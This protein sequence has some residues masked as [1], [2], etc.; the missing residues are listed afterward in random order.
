MKPGSTSTQPTHPVNRAGAAVSPGQSARGAGLLACC[1]AALLLAGC[2]RINSAPPDVSRLYQ[3][4]RAAL[5]VRVDDSVVLAAAD[6][7]KVPLRVAYPEGAGPWPLI[8]FSHGMFSSNRMYLPVFEHWAS[9]GYLVMAPNHLDADYGWRPQRNE[10]VEMLALSRGA[11]LALVMDSLDSIGQAIPQLAGKFAPP[12]YAGAGHS[13]GTYMAMLQAGLQTR[14]PVTGKVLAWPDPRIGYVVMS[15]DPG[16]MALMPEDLWLGVQVPTF[17]TTG[18][19]DFGT[20]GKGR[21]P[22]DY[23][24]ERLTG[25]GAAPGRR[26]RVLVDGLDHYYGG[27]VHRAPKD[28]RPDPQ[29][30]E[31]YLKLST[32]FLDAFVKNDA[33]ALS[34][35]RSVDLMAITAGRA[36]L[37]I[38]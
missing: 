26:F 34:Y 35:L 25:A 21:R 30:L 17:M 4:A 32:A 27:L 2:A 3:P 18:T 12:P 22:T 38:E 10:D 9:Q 7:R 29:A 19:R 31:I 8:V 36:T 13:M 33:G 15:S 20:S 1:C 23:T 37:T 14:N 5:A 24:M 16:K 11:D 28:T 6:G